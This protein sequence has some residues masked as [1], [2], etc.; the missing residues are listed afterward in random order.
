MKDITAKDFKTLILARARVE[1]DP[2]QKSFS[3]LVIKDYS[4]NMPI[5]GLPVL[6]C[7]KLGIDLLRISFVNCKFNNAVSMHNG[8]SES[9]QLQ[10]NFDNC[11]FQRKLDISG[12]CQILFD[13]TVAKRIHITDIGMLT[14]SE[15]TVKNLY[16]ERYARRLHFYPCGGNK[17]TSMELIGMNEEGAM[18]LDHCHESMAKILRNFFPTLPIQHIYADRGSYLGKEI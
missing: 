7:T 6:E 5:G 14:I 4:I 15:L 10:L 12:Q 3:M 2:H 11:V 18:H 9:I 13:N 8:Y 16:I 1:R 17:I